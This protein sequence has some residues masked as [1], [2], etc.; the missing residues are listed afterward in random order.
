MKTNNTKNDDVPNELIRITY[1]CNADCI[2]CNIPKEDYPQKE[3]DFSGIKKEIEAIL[4]KNKKAKIFLSGGEPTMSKNLFPI[5][6][7]LKKKKVGSIEVQTNG[8]RMADFNFTRKLKSK[9]VSKIFVSFHS[10]RKDIHDEIMGVK[11]SWEKCLQTIYNANKVGLGVVLNPVW[12]ELSYKDFPEYVKFVSEK[13][14]FVESISFSVVNPAGRALK[15]FKV[16]PDYE[17]IS[18][19]VGEALELAEKRGIMIIN[20]YCGLPL[21]FGSW[22]KRSFTSEGYNEKFKNG[23]GE[24]NGKT[25]LAE[26]RECSFDGNCA[27]IWTKYLKIFPKVNFRPISGCLKKSKSENRAR[28]DDDSGEKRYWVRLTYAC[29]N[30][31]IFCLDKESLDGSIVDFE[32][33]KKELEKGRS[34]SYGRVV[35]SGGEASIHPRFL[36]VVKLAKKMG[37]RHI[38]VITNGRMFS[39]RPFLEKAKKAGLTELTFSLH[40]HNENIHEGLTRIKGSFKQG[41]KGL[42]NALKTGLIVNIDI[43][44]NRKNIEYISDILLF[45]INMGI[46]E[47]D[48]LQIMPFG[49]AWDNWNDLW[50]DPE[51]FDRPLKKAFSL[52]KDKRY[53]IWTNRFPARYLEGYENLIQS[54]IKM[55]DEINGRKD[56]F[57]EHLSSGK[58]FSCQGKRCRFCVLEGFCQDFRMVKKNGRLES[59]PLPSCMRANDKKNTIRFKDLVGGRDKFDFKGFLFFYIHN[60]YFVRSTKCRSCKSYQKCQGIP[61]EIVRKFG[62]SLDK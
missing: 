6:T 61:I 5:I 44:L 34:E 26:C 8:I 62:F 10:S 36:E 9:G 21:C 30:N 23:S 2:I 56:M 31:C 53:H 13:M 29:N 40:G 27:G 41:L 58:N 48:L 28:N 51:R 46:Y 49:R 33:I 59:R 24:F 19:Y 22:H 35:L 25:K 3:R 38:Q 50:Y 57:L 12:T 45:Y 37:Y 43:V 39:Y 55:L 54:P 17:K 16:I 14:P 18:P 1:D 42:N 52:S 47:F 20:S 7:Y 4:K 11:G 60:R 15:N 32:K